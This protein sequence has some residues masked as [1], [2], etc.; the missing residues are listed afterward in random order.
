MTKEQEEALLV[1][2]VKHFSLVMVAAAA[3]LF[4]TLSSTIFNYSVT[5]SYQYQMKYNRLS[6]AGKSL[7]ASMK[8][9]GEFESKVLSVRRTSA[10]AKRGGRFFDEVAN[11]HRR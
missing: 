7:V 11:I 9:T 10:S 6:S 4:L 3:V 8:K 1:N 5:H 2:K